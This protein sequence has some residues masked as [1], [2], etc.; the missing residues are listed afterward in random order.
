MPPD[1]PVDSPNVPADSLS[2][3]TVC[4]D[5]KCNKGNGQYRQSAHV[6]RYV[7]K[8]CSLQ[9]N[10]TVDAYHVSHRVHQVEL[11]CPPRHALARREYTCL[12]YTSPSPRDGL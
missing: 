4:P 2:P 8:T 10:H 6:T 5:R 12:L 1:V 11:L 9:H 3:L 7:I